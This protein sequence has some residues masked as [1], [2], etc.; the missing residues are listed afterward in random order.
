M[1]PIC[2]L[3][4]VQEAMD[5][6]FGLEPGV[7]IAEGLGVLRVQLAS[8]RAELWGEQVVTGQTTLATHDVGWQQVRWHESF[9]EKEWVIMLPETV[10]W[11]DQKF[12]SLN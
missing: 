4:L 1:H 2:N 3:D 8:V 10:F 9:G 12:K 11:E 6:D 5:Y 7:E